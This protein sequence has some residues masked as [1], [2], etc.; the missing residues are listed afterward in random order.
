MRRING[1]YRISQFTALAHGFNAGTGHLV[2]D[3][4]RHRRTEVVIENAPDYLDRL[5]SQIGQY[6]DAG[7]SGEL[8]AG[9]PGTA[10]DQ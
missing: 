1:L 8:C 4:A 3:F 6:L 7:V 2:I 10:P 9:S 5:L